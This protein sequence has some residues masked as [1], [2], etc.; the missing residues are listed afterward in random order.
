MCYKFLPNREVCLGDIEQFLDLYTA[1]T[2]NIH[3][4]EVFCV[5]GAAHWPQVYIS[6]G[7]PNHNDRHALYMN[8]ATVTV[9]IAAM[10][11]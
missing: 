2:I 6:P 5:Q 7:T 3:V 4:Y 11:Q 1:N 9:K 10:I 8:C